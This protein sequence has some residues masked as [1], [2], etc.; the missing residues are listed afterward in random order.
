MSKTAL[1]YHSDYLSH[2]T[3]FH[4]EKAQ[5]LIAIIDYL[6]EHKFLDELVQIEP[7]LTSREWIEEIHSPY[8]I[9][10]VERACL[11]GDTILDYGDTVISAESFQVALRAVGAAIVAAD[12]IMENK[13]SNAFAAVRPPGHHAEKTQAMGFCIFN[14]IA[15]AARYL[16]KKYKLEKIFILDWD[17]H[18]GNGTQHAFEE[19]PTVFYCSLHQFPHYPGSGSERERGMGEGEG[20][21]LNIPMS[22]GSTDEE[23]IN[24]FEEKV[25]PAADS[26]SPDF[27]LISAGFDAHQD[28]PL[29]GINL[30]DDT[31]YRMSKI[32]KGIAESHCSGR[33][34][35][36]LEGGY[37]LSALAKSVA[38]HLKALME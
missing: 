15:I 16:Q 1:V 2:N 38:A 36:F 17:V 34:I 9:D 25:V 26:F 28:D 11:R 18:H 8:Y 3:G 14:N 5:R 12:Y 20:F 4:P 6:R 32:M 7:D 22:A 27:V 10:Q 21:T 33:L 30:T 19:D 29:A 31:Y 24:A 13:V 35:S 23:Y 37:N